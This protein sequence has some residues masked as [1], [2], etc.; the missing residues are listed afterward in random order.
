MELEQQKNKIVKAVEE[1]SDD[2]PDHLFTFLSTALR[3]P[4]KWFHRASWEVVIKS[5][6]VV[7]SLTQCQ[8][9]LP[10]FMSE[11]KKEK[12]E[13]WDYDTREWH[14]YI[15]M[16]AKEY[17]W[18]IEYISNLKVEDALSKIQEILIDEQ[19]EREFLWTMSDRS[20]YWDDRTKTAK[21][22]PLPRPDWMNRHIELEKEVRKTI[23]P[24]GMIP[25]GRSLTVE[26]IIAQTPVS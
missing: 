3:L 15:H 14:L 25:A 13:P 26:E 8:I 7:V 24:V 17:G 11:K 1:S 23:V 21:T 6:S 4:V 10:I 22:N 16:L 2:F 20:S 19:L 12:D 18:T 5:F 9:Q